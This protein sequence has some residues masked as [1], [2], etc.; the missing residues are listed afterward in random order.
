MTHEFS[1]VS[2]VNNIIEQIASGENTLNNIV[3]KVRASDSTV[4]YSLEKLIDAGLAEKKK[5]IT[6]ENRFF[7]LPNIP[8]KQPNIHYIV[9][10]K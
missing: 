9:I 8:K 10:Y 5:C 1:D 2:L 6:E 3:D 7:T 4:L